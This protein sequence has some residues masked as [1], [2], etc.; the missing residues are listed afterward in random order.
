M[1]S[2]LFDEFE[3]KTMSSR[4][5]GGKS[6]YQIGA[7]VGNSSSFNLSGMSGMSNFSTSYNGVP[8]QAIF[9]IIKNRDATTGATSSNTGY[10]MMLLL[11]Y[12]SRDT[13]EFKEEK[14]KEQVEELLVPL[15]TSKG[16][17]LKTKQDRINFYEDW[18]KTFSP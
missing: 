4:G 8:S 12:L 3:D 13:E 14:T 15:E 1:L 9:K 5:G 7:D 18:K 17:I 10:K 2:N 6:A 16:K 11:D